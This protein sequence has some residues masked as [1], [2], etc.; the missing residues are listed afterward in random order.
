MCRVRLWFFNNNTDMSLLIPTGETLMEWREPNA[1][2]RKDLSHGGRAALLFVLMIPT[3]LLGISAVNHNFSKGEIIL[4]LIF[5]AVGI[6]AYIRVWS[7]P[8]DVVCLK[9]NHITKVTSWPPRKTLY[10]NIECCNVRHDNYAGIKFCV[11]KFTIRRGLPAGQ[12]TK[13]AVPDDASWDRVLHILRDKSV[14]VVE[15]PLPS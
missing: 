1:Y 7:G 10:Q 11:L 13:V 2:S 6:V 3:I 14:K 8:G 15:S 5:L 9:E 12:V 4:A